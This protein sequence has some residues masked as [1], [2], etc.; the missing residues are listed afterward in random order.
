[1]QSEW[2][3]MKRKREN[4]Y[5][6]DVDRCLKP[7]HE[8]KEWNGKKFKTQQLD[9]EFNIIINISIEINKN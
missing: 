1:M 3:K 6:L 8:T 4:G 2:E 5:G 9:V 7:K